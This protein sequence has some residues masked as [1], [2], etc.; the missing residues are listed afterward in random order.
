MAEPTTIGSCVRC[1]TTANERDGATL[2]GIGPVCGPACR[3]EVLHQQAREQDDS[4]RPAT[5]PPVVEDPEKHV[6]FGHDAEGRVIVRTHHREGP[7]YCQRCG[8][9]FD[10]RRSSRR[11]VTVAWGGTQIRLHEA[12]AQ[13]GPAR[14]APSSRMFF[15]AGRRVVQEATEVGARIGRSMPERS[16]E[17]LRRVVEKLGGIR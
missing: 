4:W 15:D 10:E 7:E 11:A 1:G 5:P 17:V 12:C 8:N 14:G 9:T 16:R 13:R 3:L 6:E 2:H